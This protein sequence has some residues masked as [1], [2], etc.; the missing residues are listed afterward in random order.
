M[1]LSFLSLFPEGILL[2][3]FV[4][5]VEMPKTMQYVPHNWISPLLK[6]SLLSTEGDYKENFTKLD[7]EIAHQLM[8]GMP[9][10]SIVKMFLEYR[11]ER[12]NNILCLRSI[13]VGKQTELI[14][15]V[16]YLVREVISESARET[17]HLNLVY[18]GLMNALVFHRLYL[19]SL[20]QYAKTS[21]NL[22]ED[23]IEG[24][25]IGHG[26]FKMFDNND[27]EDFQTQ[28]VLV[29]L[30]EVSNKAKSSL[31]AMFTH[32]QTSFNIIL[33]ESKYLNAI[34][35]LSYFL[36]SNEK[37]ETVLE[38]EV[39]EE[40]PS[41]VSYLEDMIMK[42]ITMCKI[43]DEHEII[44]VIEKTVARLR[45]IALGLGSPAFQWL[46]YKFI[47]CVAAQTYQ[48][49]LE[50]PLTSLQSLVDLLVAQID[51]MEY[52]LRDVKPAKE[53]EEM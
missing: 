25:Q 19:N 16:N 30:F 31:K 27:I 8:R 47:Y 41:Y 6:L 44:V 49:L 50:C 4:Q 52:K 15:V 53:D 12:H 43:F 22:I 33:T 23:L 7:S 17:D 29:P 18:A 39:V 37:K 20:L 46:P 26:L 1:L 24:T 42:I 11:S 5:F 35:G 38:E 21:L 34:E 45:D 2:E 14:I 10:A 9:K 32:Y 28:Q 36:I 3:D 13:T 40:I 48:R 51:D